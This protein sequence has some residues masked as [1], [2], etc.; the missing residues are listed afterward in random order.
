MYIRT[1]GRCT[2]GQCT[3]G[4]RE[5]LFYRLYV[6]STIHRELPCALFYRSGAGEESVE[7]PESPG[8]DPSSPAAAPGPPGTPPDTPPV[9]IEATD[10]SD[11]EITFHIPMDSV[12]TGGH[13]A[14]FSS[15]G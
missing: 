6:Q 11:S 7:E 10:Q 5:L 4:R 8:P 13:T 9:E 15:P 1:Y 14:A 12:K 2:H 3:Y